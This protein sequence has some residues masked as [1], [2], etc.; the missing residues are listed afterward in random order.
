M[1]MW[2]SWQTQWQQACRQWQ[3]N[4]ES[5][6]TSPSAYWQT[7]AS[8]Q[9]ARAR[10]ISAWW[11][12]QPQ[13][14]TQIMSSRSW[15]E[16]CANITRW[17]GE[18]IAATA[19]INATTQAYRMHLLAQWQQIARQF[20]PA[21]LQDIQA[22]MP[23]SMPTPQPKVTPVVT[24]QAPAP[25]VQISQPA[26]VQV[27]PVPAVTA[28]PKE[29]PKPVN[30]APTVTTSLATP[31]VSK[32]VEQ[33]AKPQPQIQPQPKPALQPQPVAQQQTVVS[34]SI[35][36]GSTSQL[37][38][39]NGTT[40]IVSP[41]ANSVM[42]NGAGSTIAA[43]AAARRSVVARRATSRRGRVVPRTPR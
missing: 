7:V 17:Q 2:E 30:I 9:S 39:M 34:N 1:N 24:P 15:P 8:I 4:A 25:K 37:P 42:R 32:P 23:P 43:A 31:V 10:S 21:A 11:Q 14:I 13:A 5:V 36:A 16:W 20:T 33:Q 27:A 18:T 40:G 3:S 19:E 28:Q 12:Q 6:W 26:P 35:A 22:A 41:T 29:Q 38:L